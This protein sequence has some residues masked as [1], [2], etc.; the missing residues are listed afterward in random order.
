MKKTTINGIIEDDAIKLRATLNAR[1]KL[2]HLSP[3]ETSSL[4]HTAIINGETLKSLSEKVN[5]SSNMLSK[6]DKLNSLVN[7]EL[8]SSIVWG[9]PSG[10]QI[11]MS[12]ASEL[13]RVK[14]QSIQ[15]KIYKA[16]IKYRF[17][18]QEIIELI[19]LKKRSKLPLEACIDQV[20]NARPKEIMTIVFTGKFQSKLLIEYL[21][22]LNPKQ[23]NELL[24]KKV[25]IL[26]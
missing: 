3:L 12:V 11:S 8:R 7:D 5:V 1:R 13:G 16:I 18:K 23:R 9:Q 6:I 2:R 24:S 10:K 15:I 25:K 26:F 22:S 4:I 19:S 20:F 17:S 14:S 21:S